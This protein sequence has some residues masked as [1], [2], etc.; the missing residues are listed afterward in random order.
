V[1]WAFIFVPVHVYLRAADVIE[2]GGG[3]SQMINGGKFVPKDGDFADAE[4]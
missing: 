1:T 4:E 2:R 3:V